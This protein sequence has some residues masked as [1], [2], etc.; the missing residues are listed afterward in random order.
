MIP[1]SNHAVPVVCHI[2]VASNLSS[3]VLMKM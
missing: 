2:A 1:F 3:A